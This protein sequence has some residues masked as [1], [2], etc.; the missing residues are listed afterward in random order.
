MARNLIS[1]D[2]TI[3]SIRLGDARKRLTDGDG[4]YLLLFVKG[5]AH[6]WRFDY[7]L[8]GRRKTISFGTY[9]D[10]SLA[11]ARRKADAARQFVAEGIDPSQKRKA[12]RSR[13]RT[14]G[15]RRARGQGLAATGVVRGD[16][17]RVVCRQTRRLGRQLRR[18]N[19]GASRRMCSRG[20][21]SSRSPASRRRSCSR[22]CVA[23]RHAAWWR[24][25]TAR[26][27]TPARSFATRS[28]PSRRQPIRHAT[29]RTRSSGPTPALPRDHRSQAL[30]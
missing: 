16:R 8:H 14:P 20:L 3:K 13:A 5:G 12:E 7:S 10:T 11:L 26:C 6:G 9:P 15:R 17:A 29:S 23:S 2:A 18:Q 30:R 21:A 27:R 25:R 22:C 19:H 24:R 1:S 4:L 28:R